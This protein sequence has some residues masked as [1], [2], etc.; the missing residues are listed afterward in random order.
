V[1]DAEPGEPTGSE[2]CLYLNVYSPAFAQASVPTGE[3]RLPVMVW[4]HGGGHTIGSTSFYDGGNLA[5]SQN[6]IVVTTQYRLGPFGWFRHA[7]LGGEGA[8][9]ADRSGNYGT[10]DLIRALDWVRENVSAFGGDP[11]NVTVFG[12]S[13]GGTN[14]LSLLLSPLAKGLF[15]RAII[16]SAGFRTSDAAEAESYRDAA[17]PGD[18][19]SSRE[20]VLNLLIE[21]GAAA[22]REA[23]RKH[24]S[25]LSDAEIARYLRGKTSFEILAA[26]SPWSEGGMYRLPT[27]IRDGYVLPQEEPYALLSRADGYN[28][29]PVMLGTTRDE[30]KL[31]MYL[32]P[33]E[34]RRLF[35]IFMWLRDE[36]R[37]NLR[38]EYQAKMWKA[39]AVDGPA[40]RMREVQG[41]TVFAYRFDWDEEPTVL[42]SNLSVML[43]AAHGFEIP[44]VFGHFN[45]GERGNIIFTE[46]NE[47]GR[48]A[49][50]G[51][52]MSYWAEFAYSGDPGRGREGAL[53]RWAPWDGSSPTSDRFVVLDTEAGGGI[54]MSAD[55]V[56]KARV[57]A[58]IDS[59]GRFAS[60]KERCTLY[61]QLAQWS[62]LFTEEDYRKVACTAY[63]FVAG[64]S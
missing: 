22:D 39:A 7:A 5:A 58:Q 30:N 19:F 2:D 26:Y 42:V 4:I 53:P 27:V 34:V 49:L 18:E 59:D 62:W 61:S 51:A 43:G 44:F 48:R 54:R 33:A 47:P 1:A 57:V 16:Q 52:M 24:A 13:A 21:D 50:S 36:R 31:F 56:D 29:V 32:D 45:L 15:H 38:A 35:W 63:P 23:A 25:G 6:L 64:G 60:Q 20:A 17:T 14:V 10:L 8:S 41:P 55:W 9:D 40:A 28:A 37:Y 11:G 3:E 46:E 12:E